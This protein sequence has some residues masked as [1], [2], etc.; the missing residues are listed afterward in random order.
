MN[1]DKTQIH[2]D[3]LKNL[4][5]SMLKSA[6]ICVPVLPSLSSYLLWALVLLWPA[7][8]HPGQVL[9]RPREQFSDL[10]LSHWPNAEFLRRALFE[11]HQFPLW[12]PS[13]LNGAPFA[14][15]PLAGLWY[16]PNWLAVILP[17]PFAFNLLFALH[18]AWAGWGMYRWARADGFGVWPALIGG[19]TYAAAPK[20]MAHLAAGHVS[21][22]FAV[23]WMPW[24]LKTIDEGRRTKDEGRKL[25]FVLRPSSFVALVWALIFLADVRWGVYAAVVLG[26]WW[27]A[28][29]RG[30][31]GLIICGL[32]FLLLTAVLWA[33]LAEFVRY[34]A[35]ADLTVAEAAEFSL[36]PSYLLGLL[37]PDLGGFHEYMTYLGIAPLVLAM[38]GVVKGRDRVGII[39]IVGLALVSLWWALGPQAGLFTLVTDILNLTLLRVPPRTWFIISLAASWL[40][41]RGAAAVEEGAQPSGRAWNLASV[42]VIAA[43]W[44]LTIGG[45]LIRKEILIHFLIPTLAATTT[46][47]GLRL[48]PARA[49]YLLAAVVISELF[50]VDS[51]LIES[52]P[53]TPSPAAEWLS[54]QPGEWRVYSP[55]FSLPPLNAAQAGIEQADG[56]NPLQLR[57]TVTFMEAATGV[58]SSGYSIT[59]PPFKPDPKT[60]QL[61]IY[62]ANAGAIP[63]A[64]LLG[65]LN[66]RYVASEFDIQSAGLTLATKVGNTRIYQNVYDECRVVGGSLIRRSPNQIVVSAA[67]PGRVTLSELWYPG[68]EATVDSLPATLERVDIFR[69]VKVEAGTH[70][71]V[72][73]FRPLTV[74]AGL[75]LSLTGLL[76]IASCIY[77]KNMANLGRAGRTPRAP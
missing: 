3:F 43:L 8:L 37:V 76:I 57:D 5:S 71:I 4:C 56:V 2:T 12:N 69:S 47:I 36:P 29:R 73:E 65:R 62:T 35:R 49:L 52:R 23:A 32:L 25:T 27:L 39:T 77:R 72:F 70:E 54:R 75:G 59:L 44:I 74:Y 67:G 9:M 33:P 38:I 18:L 34:S 30:L 6:F 55:S 53:I 15:D 17:L 16:P 10:L 66:V 40:A 61:D 11:F 45:S 21:L 24:L 63:E 51:T 7:V 41:V 20:I 31:S 28:C 60:N 48:K 19:V 64:K 42:G 68:W 14:A 26:V 13:I 22:V 46:L 58:T 50:V 1:T